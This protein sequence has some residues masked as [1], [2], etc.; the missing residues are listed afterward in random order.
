MLV[1]QDVQEWTLEHRGGINDADELGSV[2]SMPWKIQTL[3]IADPKNSQYS[4]TLS[5]E[6]YNGYQM[7]KWGFS[8]FN[9]GRDPDFTIIIFLFFIMSSR[10]GLG[11]NNRTENIHIFKWEICQVLCN[12]HF[13]LDISKNIYDILFISIHNGVEFI[14]RPLSSVFEDRTQALITFSS[15]RRSNWYLMILIVNKHRCAR[16]RRKDIVTPGVTTDPSL[17]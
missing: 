16:T 14:L 7:I 17:Y 2:F 15:T 12:L 5:Y 13:W 4:P 9:H 6:N 10:S 8:S 11:R 3:L 1:W